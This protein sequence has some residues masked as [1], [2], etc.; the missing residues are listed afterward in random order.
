VSAH[1]KRANRIL[2]RNLRSLPIRARKRRNALVPILWPGFPRKSTLRS[3]AT[4]VRN[5]GVHIPHTT[6]DCCRFEKDRKEKS[7]F[8]AAK[9]GGYTSNPVNQNFAQLTDKIEKLEKALKRF[10]KKGQ[11]CHYED[12]DSNSE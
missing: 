10:A 12:S 7:S 3:I 2:T 6:L 4:C 8:R 11:K 5:V 9:K 1:I